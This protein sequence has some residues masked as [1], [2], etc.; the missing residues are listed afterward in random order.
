VEPERTGS[1]EK[2]EPIGLNRAYLV[3]SRDAHA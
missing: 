1:R 2:S 3:G